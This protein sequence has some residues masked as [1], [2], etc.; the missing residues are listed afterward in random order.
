MLKKYV[1]LVFFFLS[2]FMVSSQVKSRDVFVDAKKLLQEEKYGLAQGLFYQVYNDELTIEPQKEEALFYIAICSKRLFNEDARFWLENF[3]ST[4]PYSPKISTVNYE[5][6]L[7]YYEKKLY[8]KTI[9]YFLSCGYSSD[10][11]NFKLAYSYFMIDSLSSSKYYFSKLLHGGSKYASSSRYF[12]AHI[13]Y[14]QKHYKTALSTFLTLKDDEHFANI[15]PYY[16]SQIYFLLR[17]YDEL[18]AYAEPMLDKVISSREAELNRILAEAYYHNKDYQSATEYLEAYFLKATYVNSLDKLLAGH[19]Y[20]NISDYENAISY[21]EPLQF[22]ADSCTQFSAYYLANSY[23]QLDEKE[24]ALTAFRKA[25][26]INHN[27]LLQEDAF[28]NYAKLSYELD[29]PFD[30][31]LSILQEYLT[32][33]KNTE[34]KEWVNNLMINAFQN[35]NRYTEALGKLK[36][37]EYPSQ[38][39]K[40]AIQRLSFFIGVV[41]FNNGDYSQAITFFENANKFRLNEDIF[42]MSTYWLADSYFQL[43][44]Y[45]KSTKLYNNYL[46]LS[47]SSLSDFAYYN[48]G[49]SYF[50]QKDYQKAKNSFRKFS[51]VAED[52][53]RLN[54]AY[55]RIADC[56]FMLSDFRMAEKN[57]AKAISFTLF[58]VDYAL[59]KQS[60]CLGLVGRYSAKESILKQI[61]QGHQSSI[62]F[63]DAL[64]DLAVYYK[65]SNQK[66]KSLEFYDQLLQ[67]TL[68]EELKAKIYL[69]KGMIYF[70]SGDFDK[71]TTSFLIV[72]NDFAKTRVFKDALA[73][74][75]AAYI[76]IA[77]VDEYL[78]IINDLPQINIS[79]AEQD[80]L[81]YNTAFMKFAEADYSVA[82]N[83][84]QQYISNFS[85]GIF[86][87]DANYYLAESCKQENDSAC[88]LSA[89]NEV[90]KANSKHL[91]PA[92]LYLARHYFNIL[93]FD[94]SAKY[95]QKL[96]IIASNNSSK[97]E[98]VIR[99]MIIF[100]KLDDAA[101]NVEEY[102]EKVL[103][104]DKVDQKLKNKAELILARTFFNNGNFQKA[105]KVFNELSVKSETVI[106]AEAT[107][108]LA[109]FSFLTDS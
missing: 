101:K 17:R 60:V 58:D 91:E 70:N 47:L 21:L 3:V 46:T 99:L 98:A 68:D 78:A 72:I 38:D 105:E 18:I 48:L 11:C 12:Y 84:I 76:S 16:V 92:N 2:V 69:N 49:Y 106:G 100:E 81:T 9:D 4:Y 24:Y 104:L 54:D 15:V 89:F 93:D 19:A 88:I 34:H 13:A 53:M 7:Y 14:K 74:L 32:T 45:S 107:Y 51:K 26:E 79:R 42:L 62:Y 64:L 85:D 71:A 80:S 20:H 52:S 67:F 108:M 83:T 36:A 61:I 109:Y 94:K 86:I 37:I 33:F 56:Y 77:K 35:T 10:E 44:D 8:D 75:R 25:A 1:V 63:D 39:Q 50:Q 103:Q 96:E 23:L 40:M 55:L 41:T 29:L 73:G 27:L 57:Y 31:V 5:M 59:Y 90:I 65:N 30:N 97:R 22:D 82:R 43:S 28:F 66:E 6:G 95:Y 87:V 102:A